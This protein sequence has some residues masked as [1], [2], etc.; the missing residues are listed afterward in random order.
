M[1]LVV[2]FFSRMVKKI[3]RPLL[4][5]W[6]VVL[7][8]A[9][10]LSIGKIYFHYSEMRDDRS[11]LPVKLKTIE[12]VYQIAGDKPFASFQYAPH[13]YDFDWQ[14]LYF[15][16]AANGDRLPTEFAYEPNVVPY[17]VEKPDLLNHF[18][19][20]VDGRS[21]EIIFYIVEEPMQPSLLVSWWQRQQFERIVETIKISDEVTLYM[22]EPK[23]VQY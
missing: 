4:G 10:F 23:I 22:A 2:V 1:P 20:E 5:L 7:L 14:Y 12:T 18:S 3:P 17:I 16:R 13:I 21:P 6:I 15:W 11:F 9:P 8:I 19:S